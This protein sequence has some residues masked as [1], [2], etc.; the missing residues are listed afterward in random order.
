MIVCLAVGGMIVCAMRHSEYKKK[1]KFLDRYAALVGDLDKALGAMSKTSKMED[2][3]AAMDRIV[4]AGGKLTGMKC[5]Q[6]FVKHDQ[7]ELEA[8]LR[9]EATQRGEE[10]VDENQVDVE[11]ANRQR[12]MTIAERRCNVGSKI[13]LAF[14]PRKVN[15]RK[16]A[17]MRY[18][19]WAMPMFCNTICSIGSTGTTL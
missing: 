18:S 8:K 10:C 5:W 15:M 14:R 9:E 11:I 19:F 1:W 17:L 16:T 3:F 12:L 6:Y 13:A 7:R 2:V 4:E